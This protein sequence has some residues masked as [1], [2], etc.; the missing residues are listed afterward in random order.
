MLQMF[1]HSGVLRLSPQC[2][3]NMEYAMS[4]SIFNVN[5]R[6]SSW[7]NYHRYHGDW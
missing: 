2:G 4:V 7:G 1:A 6:Q 5:W 3:T